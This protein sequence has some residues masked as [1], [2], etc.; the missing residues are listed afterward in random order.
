VYPRAK[1]VELFGHVRPSGGL[2]MRVQAVEQAT[3]KSEQRTANVYLYVFAWQTP[4]LSGRPRAFHRSELPFIFANTDR[5]AQLTGGTEEARVLAGR[6]ADAWVHFARTGN[7]NHGDLPRWPSFTSAGIET[8]VFDR[9][10]SVERDHDR[11]ARLA[12]RAA[13]TA[14]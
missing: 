10:C 14:I 13:T 5:C 2:D 6:M 11:S 3:R 7:P 9:V 8:M 4:L 12:Y 1:P